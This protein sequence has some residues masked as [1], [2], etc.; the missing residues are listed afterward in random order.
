VEAETRALL[1]R[2]V[3][4]LHG[5]ALSAFETHEAIL[6]AVDERV[7]GMS[8]D[9]IAISHELHA[10]LVRLDRN[11]PSTAGILLVAPDGHLA[12]GSRS[13]VPALPVDLAERDYVRGHLP[14]V[15]PIPLGAG[16]SEN[17]TFVGAIAVELTTGARVF[18]LSRARS[19]GVGEPAAGTIGATFRPGYFA[20]FYAAVLKGSGD[21]ALLARL[22]GAV[23]AI[24]PDGEPTAQRLPPRSGLVDAFSSASEQ[25]SMRRLH[26]SGAE[27]LVA[28]RRLSEGHPVVI[29]YGLHASALKRDWLSRVV[30]PAFG[31]AAATAL[32]LW[33]TARAQDS[34]LR[35]REEAE[36]RAD[37]EARLRRTEAGA[38]LGQLAAGVAHDFGNAVQSVA[39]GARL[40]E[41]D[42]EHPERVRRL[43]VLIA[44][45]AERGS[46][47]A[48]RML[49]FARRGA[50][51][52]G[53]ALLDPAPVLADTADLLGRTLGAGISVRFGPAVPPPP[54]V[55]ADRAELEAVVVNLAVNARDAMPNG[56]TI[57]IDTVAEAF[58]AE[59]DSP[60]PDLVPGLYARIAVRD[61]GTGMDAAT[62]ARAEEAFFTTKPEGKGT[63]LG[64]SMA[65]GFAR[66]AGGAMRIESAPGQGTTV[67]L[68][69]PAAQAG[70]ARSGNAE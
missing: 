49:S 12:A 61:T 26:A 2:T 25:V 1:G 7:R 3:E 40:L 44:G 13:P 42:A 5:H 67:T 46:A 10:F 62:L 33:L 41:R 11:T 47:L 28:F 32:L 69:L 6:L 22:D 57:N 53:A 19:G 4:M 24:H 29:L 14:E 52:S 27:R 30:G 48:S 65:R 36:R 58:A 23:L 39:G 64:L 63:G 31:A 60:A 17:D 16:E 8:W 45:A 35:S 18:S 20:D 59:G 70:A 34:A 50:A 9:D 38:A 43:A 68:W 54:A 37:L 55:S 21:V 56:G 66:S 15:G 51:G